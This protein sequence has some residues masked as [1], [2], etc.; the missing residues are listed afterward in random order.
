VEGVNS[1]GTLEVNIGFEAASESSAE[2]DIWQPLSSE[3]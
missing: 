1:T 3:S 2:R